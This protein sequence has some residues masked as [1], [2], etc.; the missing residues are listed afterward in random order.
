[1]TLAIHQ[2]TSSVSPVL[3]ASD[4]RL[5]LLTELAASLGYEIV[6]VAG[7][8]DQVSAQSG[9]QLSA[10]QDV[11]ASVGMMIEANSQ[12]R[13]TVGDV[14]QTT[15]QTLETVENSVEF[16][17]GAG[18]RSHNVASWVTAL[19]ERMVQVADSLEAVKANNSEIAA[20]ARQVNILAINAK[21]EAARAGESGRGF[22]VVAEAINELSQKTAKAAEGIAGNV[23]TLSGWVGTLR[24]ESSG[25]SEDASKVIE[26][27]SETD[28][29]LSNIASGV[30]ETN[31]QA[32]RIQE[33]AGK[34]RHAMD[35]FEP[36]FARIT[37][38]VEA[39]AAGI[40]QSQERANALIDTTE[41][42]VQQ[43]VE[44]GG[45]SKDGRFINRVMEDAAHISQLFSDAIHVGAIRLEDLFDRNYQ[46]IEG[47]NPEQF[48]TKFSDFC[49]QTLP[50]VLEAA[51]D[52]DPSVAFCVTVDPNGYVPTHQRK[53]SQP[54]GPD[55]EWNIA[56][57]RNR[58]M[59]SDRVGLKAGRNTEAFLL[60]VYR[61]DM[62]GGN[63]VLMKYLSAPIFVK[64]RHWG[65]LSMGYRA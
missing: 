26:G 25:V 19:S 61:R 4:P 52:F 16:V 54:Q 10:L 14:A 30:R 37:K 34:V 63:F 23:N 3:S 42:I 2:D 9:D 15:A 60:Q 57:C 36:A 27:S 64:D 1:M 33:G 17:R 21:I 22:G 43:T 51:M 11:S 39:T 56:N 12:V 40:H 18:Q 13:N 46:K 44:L 6:D 47:T 59:F 29:A 38:T 24:E 50:V 58:R 49:D 65:G 62:G 31:E 32:L 45:Q 5:T 28:E 41:S 8:L 55:V 53:F 48:V 35:Q 7:F 20:I